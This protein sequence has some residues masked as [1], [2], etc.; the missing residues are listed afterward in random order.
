MATYAF[1]TRFRP[2]RYRSAVLFVA[3]MAATPASG[4]YRS[5]LPS[6]GIRMEIRLHTESCV[7]RFKA[8]VM[9]VLGLRWESHRQGVGLL[10]APL[11]GPLA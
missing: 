11:S 9:V 5:I 4:H 6:I 8:S 1:E 3:D 2:A 10:S 7:G